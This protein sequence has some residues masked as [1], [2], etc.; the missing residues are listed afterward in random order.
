[1]EKTN[2]RLQRVDSGTC[3][4]IIAVPLAK[5]ATPGFTSFVRSDRLCPFLREVLAAIEV[6]AGMASY[7]LR[8]VPAASFDLAPEHR[9]FNRKMKLELDA[10]V[11]ALADA[12]GF[13]VFA[14]GNSAQ[15]GDPPDDMHAIPFAEPL[16][17]TDKSGKTVRLT[18]SAKGSCPAHSR[19]QTAKPQRGL[20]RLRCPRGVRA[21]GR[22]ASC[23]AC[24]PHSLTFTSLPSTR[25][26]LQ[27]SASRTMPRPSGASWT[28]R[29]G[30][31]TLSRGGSLCAG[32]P[33][34]PTSN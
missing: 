11:R 6:G 15:K 2:L 26:L 32:S 4:E 33:S 29:A 13:Y 22:L 20:T 24:V 34:F 19:H 21:T 12:A 25:G 23:E 10:E 31:C 14:T 7:H 16:V 8:V 5:S 28:R 27:T 1:M 9:C 17:F 3:T 30:P 18:V